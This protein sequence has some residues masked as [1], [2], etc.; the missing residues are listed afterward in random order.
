MREENVFGSA[1][2][3]SHATETVQLS[4][5]YE[6]FKYIGPEENSCSPYFS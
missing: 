2:K 4:D 1:P 3:I 6:N 5:K